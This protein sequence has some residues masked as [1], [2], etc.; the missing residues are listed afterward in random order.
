MI[1]RFENLS[2][3]AERRELRAADELL[4]LQP[5]VFDLVLYL[6]RN[7]D[8]V[9]S[10]D[11]LLDRLWPGVV[12]VEGAL[13]RAMSLARS[14]LREACG[15]DCIRTHARKG[16]RFVAEVT[17]E[18]D[19]D[20]RSGTGQTGLAAG[21][22]QAKP[23]IAVLPFENLG[24][25]PDQALIAE[26][27]AE[28]ISTALSR[29]RCLVVISR[30]SSRLYRAVSENLDE[31]ATELGVRYLLTGSVRRADADLRVHVELIDSASRVQIWAETYDREIDNLFQILDEITASVVAEIEP[32]F[33]QFEREQARIKS[34]D[35]LD[36]WSVYQRGLWH[37]YQFTRADV[38]ASLPLFEQAIS[39]DPQFAPA[40]AGASFCHFSNAYLEYAENWLSAVEQARASAEHAVAADNRCPAA[41]WSM[42]R[43][44]L[45]EGELDAAIGE[46][47]V[48]IE[49]NPNFAHAFYMLGWA[50]VLAGNPRDGLAHI[51][52]AENL[53]PRDPLLFAFRMVRAMGLLLQGDCEQAVHYSTRAVRQPNSHQHTLAV[54]VAALTACG[55]LEEARAAAERLLAIDPDYSCAAFAQVMPYRSDEDLASVTGPLQQAGIPRR[56]SLRPTSQ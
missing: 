12:V 35:N 25:D 10:K 30:A 54:Q 23:A 37:L 19:T 33:S 49:L 47:D 20:A 39:L 52:T 24:N 29:L 3:D 2:L 42:G 44:L 11:E 8:R 17:E 40:H 31:A 32:E 38:V 51:D 15:S 13:Q 28:D 50:T 56:S 22:P 53:S 45:L 46:F 27:L 1:Y 41:H 9:V 18:A 7:R 21:L 26:G 36:A 4:Q 14:C 43:A 16:Y 55:R 48:S 6:I 5:R 34:P